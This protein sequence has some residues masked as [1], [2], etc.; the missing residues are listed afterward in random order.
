MISYPKTGGGTAQGY[1]AEPSA[2]AAAGVVVIQEWWGLQGQIRS[3][4]D[5]FAAE[6]FRAIAPDLFEGKVIPYHDPGAAKSA[7]GALDLEAVTDSTVR[8]A[9][10][11]LARGG[12][13][14]GLV[15]FCM[16]GAV[17][18]VGA[19]RVPELAAAVCFYG[20]PPREVAAAGDV[21]V[22]FQGHFASK[23][24]WCTPQLV[25]ALEEELRAAG[26]TYEIHR[27][28][29][30]HAFMNSDRPEAYDASAARLGWDRCL[31]FLREHLAAG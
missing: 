4:C 7:M 14:V 8:G 24:Y 18:V 21:R 12:L 19:V 22:P 23:D 3:V 9:V 10:Q 30:S 17:A 28:E 13:E 31:A 15:G 5:R 16:G 2:P 11:H 20:L 26:N 27:Y 6:G 25:A 1:L 29:A